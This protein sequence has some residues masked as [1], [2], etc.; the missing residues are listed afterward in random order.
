MRAVPPAQARV[1]GARCETRGV[2]EAVWRGRGW[3]GKPGQERWGLSRAV[4][5]DAL[6]REEVGARVE[7]MGAI[8]Y[9]RLGARAALLVPRRTL[10][11]RHVGDGSVEQPPHA[12]E[13]RRL[14][15]EVPK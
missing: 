8:A 14:R 6:E 13:V 1:R 10:R 15:R 9:R 3:R 5:E 4:Y 2:A 11:V 7:A 12:V